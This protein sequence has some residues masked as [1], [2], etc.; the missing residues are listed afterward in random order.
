MPNHLTL[1]VAGGRK[2]QGL[3]DHCKALPTDRRVL[4][5]TFTQTNQQELSRRLGSQVGNLHNLEVL[6]WYTFLLRHFAKPFL[7]FKFSGER[8]G[9]FNF[10]G[11]PGQYAKGRHRF[12]DGSNHLY[13][14]ELGRLASELMATTPALLRR[15]ECLYDEILIDEVQ[16]LSGYDWDILRELLRS[17]ID[18]RMVGDVRQAVLS[19]N[20]RGQKNKQYG[21][22]AALEWFRKQEAE[23]YL[24]IS[25]ARKTYRCRTEI[26]GFSDS[27]FHSA[28]GFPETESENNH[29][30]GHDGVFLVHSQHVNQYVNRFRPQCLRYSAT[31][32]KAFSLEFMNFKAS[33]G[34]TFERV[35]I[36]PTAKIEAFIKKN[37]HLEATSAAAFY[38]AVTRA[39]QSVAIILDNPS[40]SALP[41]WTP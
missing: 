35:L 23:G 25:F 13:A 24:S 6:G 21:Y 40:A 33:K 8:V 2:T 14:C 20:P 7:P 41:V 9:G 22:A 3:V 26:A 34:A 12:M 10:E 38:V 19:T 15:L 30:T 16:D 31:S 1:A 39:E 4:V 28:W 27:I 18:I 32:A 36:A 37:V 29:V 17:R 5:V 11:R